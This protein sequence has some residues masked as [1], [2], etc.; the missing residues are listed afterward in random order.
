MA[1]RKPKPKDKAAESVA[2]DKDNARLE[3]TQGGVTTRDDATDLGVP[4]LPGSADEPQ[5]PED[6]LGA[7][8]KRGDYRGRLGGADY[9]PHET[10]R[11]PDAKPGEAHTRVVAQRPRAA[12]LGDEK[13]RKGGVQTG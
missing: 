2:S 12:E 5:G 1:T 7:G 9:E 13:G 8:P 3:H 11:I 6:A 4:M 10:V